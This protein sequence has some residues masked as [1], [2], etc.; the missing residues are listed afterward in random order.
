MENRTKARIRNRLFVM[1]GKDE[2]ET[3]GFTEDISSTDLFIK[4]SAVL[5]PGTILQIGLIPPDHRTLTITGQ[6]MWAKQVSQTLLQFSKKSGTGIQI[7]QSGDDHKQFMPKIEDGIK[8]AG[9]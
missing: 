5:D 8:G 7:T 6:V 2:P 1:F 9:S 4:T 3:L